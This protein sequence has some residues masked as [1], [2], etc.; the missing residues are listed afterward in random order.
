MTEFERWLIENGYAKDQYDLK[1]IG[2]KSGLAAFMTKPSANPNATGFNPAAD[3]G[4]FDAHDVAAL[5]GMAY[6]KRSGSRDPRNGG[7]YNRSSTSLH[8][9]NP[10]VT[11]NND[12]GAS[13]NSLESERNQ[14]VGWLKGSE[15]HR[16]KLEKSIE[17][18]DREIA[19]LQAEIAMSEA[20]DPMYDLAV[21]RM[22]MND[23]MSLMND[24]RGR[25]SKKIDQEFQMKQKKA[26]QEFQHNEN[27]LN[28]QNTLEVSKANKEEQKAAQQKDLDNAFASAKQVYDFAVGDL[29]ANPTDPTLKRDVEKAK[30]L[31]RQAAI[32]ANRLDEFTTDVDSGSKDKKF[33]EIYADYEVEGMKGLKTYLENLKKTNLKAYERELKNLKARGMTE[34]DLDLSGAEG[35]ITEEKIKASETRKIKIKSAVKSYGKGEAGKIARNKAYDALSDDVKSEVIKSYKDGEYVIKEKGK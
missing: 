5:A 13:V 20:G 33:S 16:A 24:I 26:D 23:D 21:M 8:D 15:Q 28:R 14:S 11:V 31:Y 4:P 32:K 7:G 19:K 35:K 6:S 25:I 17:D 2:R 9:F 27:E 22:I 12:E 3:Y 30:E 18:Y 29:E 10:K 34:G 1:D